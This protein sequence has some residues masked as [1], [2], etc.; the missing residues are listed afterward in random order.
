MKGKK[1]FIRLFVAYIILVLA[2]ASVVSIFY[3]QDNTR[4]I[5]TDLESKRQQ[6]LKQFSSSMDD[7]ISICYNMINKLLINGEL[8][9]FVHNSNTDYYNVLQIYDEL[10]DSQQAFAEMGFTLAVSKVTD[11]LVICPWGTM[12]PEEYLK[13]QL[14]IKQSEASLILRR[15]ID[16]DDEMN[17]IIKGRNPDESMRFLMVREEM[18]DINKKIHVFMTFFNESIFSNMDLSSK[19]AIF[20]IKDGQKVAYKSG[21]KNYTFNINHIKNLTDQMGI[22]HEG[23]FRIDDKKYRYYYIK[24][25]LVDWNYIYVT[26][27]SVGGDVSKLLW[28]SILVFILMV[29]TGTIISLGIASK[30]YRPINSIVD[31]FRG[32]GEGK[33]YDEIRYIRENAVK[34]K[35]TNKQLQEIIQTSKKP[36]KEKGLRD[37]LSGMVKSK[38]YKRQ[39]PKSEYP[40]LYN[41]NTVVIL[42]IADYKDITKGFSREALLTIEEEIQK[43]LHDHLT[44]GF[45][46]ELVGL[47]FKSYAVIIGSTDTKRIDAAFNNIILTIETDYELQIVAAIGTSC[48]GINSIYNSYTNALYAL[49]ENRYT[50]GKN[51]VI[52]ASKALGE[53]DYTY[54]YPIE[55]EK[56]LIMS[57]MRGHSDKLNSIISS[58]IAENLEKRHLSKEGLSNLIY[59]VAGTVNRIVSLSGKPFVHFFKEG[60]IIYLELKKSQSAEDLKKNIKSIF[61]R[62]SKLI[63]LDNQK[64]DNEIVE[65]MLE[66][67]HLN[68]SKDISQLEIAEKF[69]ISQCYASTLFKKYTGSN[70]KYY[71]NEYRVKKAKEILLSQKDVKIKELASK[72]GCNSVSSFIRLF[73]RHE[74]ISPGKYCDSKDII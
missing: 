53:K 49:E 74:G 8:K 5:K 21:L 34:I 70:F 31:I 43:I 2:Y 46:F 51:I 57:V 67:I 23:N 61:T 47:D 15:I 59:S 7:R 66:Y 71:L 33:V 38:Q 65:E 37:L 63:Y 68:Y 55:M 54:Y 27:T 19:E 73:K 48:K 25:S 20:I 30:M 58:V 45:N 10:V 69:N 39:F 11:N 17:Y 64:T 22:S 26:D 29:I 56:E 60:T 18:V 36:L 14:G 50:P 12:T 24:S 4:M 3:F 62:L 35:N 42:E 13:E 6:I 1:F 52:T 28:T 32:I 9:T 40:V 16:K 41:E 72:V 44:K